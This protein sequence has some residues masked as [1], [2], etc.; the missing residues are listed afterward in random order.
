MQN[1]FFYFKII[2]LNVFILNYFQVVHA[3]LKNG[4]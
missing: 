2:M 1:I 3:K 4:A